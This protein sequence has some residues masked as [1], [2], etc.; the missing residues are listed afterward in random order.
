MNKQMLG[1]LGIAVIL[2]SCQKNEIDSENFT[3]LEARVTIGYPTSLISTPIITASFPQE[4]ID[5]QTPIDIIPNITAKIRT[6][7]PTINYGTINLS[8][9][10]NNAG[11]NLK[12][13]LDA[14][15]RAN[16]YVVIEGKQYNLAQFHYHYSSEHTFKG[17]HSAMEVHFVNIAADNSYAVLGTM[18]ELGDENEAMGTLIDN[19]PTTSGGVNSPNIPFDLTDLLPENT[20]RYYTYIGSLTTPNYGANSAQTNGGPVTWI[21]FKN[22]QELSMEQF[23]SYETIY[24][25]PNFRETQPLNGRTLYE[26]VGN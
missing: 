10:V 11:E 3:A 12:I 4:I 8:S 9:V 24:E 23:D 6:A 21:L 1:I 7:T 26:T 5:A 22:K 25:E 14:A 20:G 17:R 13:N 2:S 16:N 18:I 19:S 15:D